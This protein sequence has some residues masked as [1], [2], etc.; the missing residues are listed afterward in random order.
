MEKDRKTRI[1]RKI[2]G[3]SDRP[4]LSIFVSNKHI[5]AQIIDDASGNTL[6]A[7]RDAEMN[8]TGKSQDVAQKIGL[9]IAARAR[10][11]GVK[12]VV[13][14]RGEKKY[15]GRIKALAK[16]ARAGGLDF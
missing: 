4:R 6:A 9:E 10:E 5:Y 15:H 11:I 13:F 14:D 12:H 2:R 8:S 16:G 7:A 1:R 3:R